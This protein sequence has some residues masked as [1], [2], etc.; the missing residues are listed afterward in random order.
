M[1]QNEQ[2]VRRTSFKVMKTTG[3]IRRTLL[4]FKSPISNIQLEQR[5]YSNRFNLPANL[6]YFDC[7]SVYIF[8]KIIQFDLSNGHSGQNK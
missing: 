1:L 8:I 3:K 5:F 7:I 4:I 6:I 2:V